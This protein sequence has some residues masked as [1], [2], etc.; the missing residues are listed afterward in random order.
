MV[1]KILLY[2]SS[3]PRIPKS[4]SKALTIRNTVIEYIPIT[5]K[6]NLINIDFNSKSASRARLELYGYD[7][8]VKYKAKNIFTA[9]QLN[10]ELKMCIAK[11][12]KMPMG[13]LELQIRQTHK[14]TRKQT[15]LNTKQSLRTQKG[16]NRGTRAKLLNKCGL[17]DIPETSH[18]F[19]D[20]THHTCCMLGSRAREYADASG[21]PIGSLSSKVQTIKNP[22]RAIKYSKKSKKVLTP[23]CTCTGSKVCTFYTDKFGKED[24]THIKFIG[25]LSGTGSDSLDEEKAINKLE[26]NR[27]STPGIT[28]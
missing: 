1:R 9:D 25:R 28:L 11:I 7:G 21:N 10:K 14:Q 12:D 4:I 19:A 16:G 27:H 6:S 23:W 22:A 17:P 13:S 24:G 8:S 26:L 5:K 15:Q 3:K 18:C 2:S 20:N